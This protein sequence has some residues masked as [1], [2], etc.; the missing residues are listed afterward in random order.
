MHPMYVRTYWRGG[1][2]I[3]QPNR[4]TLHVS[5]VFHST[6]GLMIVGKMVHT[7]TYCKIKWLC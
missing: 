7:K 4:C 6:V 1:R 2:F 5:S 3:V